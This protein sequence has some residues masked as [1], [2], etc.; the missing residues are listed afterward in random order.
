MSWRSRGAEMA[1]VGAVLF[2]AALLGVACALFP[3]WAV[4]AVAFALT[5]GGGLGVATMI[6]RSGRND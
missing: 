2:Y 1:F 6:S 4:L 5:V 3:V